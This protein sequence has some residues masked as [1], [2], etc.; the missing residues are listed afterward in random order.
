MAAFD[1]DQQKW[2]AKL[3]DVPVY[4]L[5]HLQQY[6][7]ENHVNIGV[8]AVPAVQ[9][10]EVAEKLVACGILAIWNF[11]PKDLKLPPRVV[12]Q[13]TDLATSFAVLS[14]KVKRKMAKEDL[15]EEDDEW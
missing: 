11:A 2:G 5:S 1:I 6:L 4:P 14:A 7:E 3:G 15:L 8:I 10:Q 9:A 12:V 13:R